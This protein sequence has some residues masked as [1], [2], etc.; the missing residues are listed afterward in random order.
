M[1]RD[2]LVVQKA[3]YDGG[4]DFGGVFFFKLTI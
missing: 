1:K 2:K 4:I 3:Q